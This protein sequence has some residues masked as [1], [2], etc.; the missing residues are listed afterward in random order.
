MEEFTRLQIAV[1]AA[2]V[3]TDRFSTGIGVF[4]DPLS[5]RIGIKISMVIAGPNHFALTTCS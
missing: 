2:L 1:L 4:Y 5:G 3:E